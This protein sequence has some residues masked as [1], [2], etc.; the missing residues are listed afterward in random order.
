HADVVI[1]LI[2]LSGIGLVAAMNWRIPGAALIALGTFLNVIVIALN[3]GMPYEPAIIAAA[4]APT[5]NDGLHMVI[6]AD[7]RVPFLADIIPFGLAHGVY[8]IGDFLLAFGG[9]L[10]PFV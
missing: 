2:G 3:G 5:P 8:S 1:Y 10:I 6:G 7:T 4:S 9:F